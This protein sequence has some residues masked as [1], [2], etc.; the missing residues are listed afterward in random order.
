MLKTRRVFAILA[1]LSLY[2]TLQIW[3][4]VRY[5]E[6]LRFTHLEHSIGN[7]TLGFQ[8]ILVINLP[9]RTD[10]RDAIS[11]AAALTNLTV[12]YVPGID[13]SEVQ[14]RVLP[15]D[16][17]NKSIKKGNVG[18]WRAH[19]NALRTIV[20]Q[21]LTTVLILEDDVDWDVRLKSQLQLFGA[22]SRAYLQPLKTNPSQTLSQ[23]ALTVPLSS[24]P[25]TLPPS[26]SPYG[27]DW[28]V[29][30]LGHCGA[31]LPPPPPPHTQQQHQHGVDTTNRNHHLQILLAADTT[32]PAPQHLKAH[33]FASEPDALATLHPPH[34]RVVHA[35]TANVCSNGYAVSRRGARRLLHALGIESFTAGFDLMLRDWCDYDAAVGHRGPA[36]GR[37]CLTVQPPLFSHF[38]AKGG[39]D[40]QGLGGGYASRKRGSA[41]V[42]LSVRRNLGGLSEGK[43]VEELIDQWPSG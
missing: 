31:N 15:A 22:A 26:T 11:L 12:E 30:W 20:E 29:L 5:D 3:H 16:S 17:R 7:S 32:V 27:D 10:R 39:S 37:V 41:Y 6:Q 21:D 43:V 13:G 18:S 1:V 2:L 40:I 23:A 8:K 33:P 28:D 36:S 35:A 34:T 24:A 4:K 19:I 42:R 9:S 25:A 14:E 38:A